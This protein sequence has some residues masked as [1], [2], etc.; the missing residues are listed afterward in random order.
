MR[1]AVAIMALLFALAIVSVANA[2][3]RLFEARLMP[4]THLVLQQ[5]IS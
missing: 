5:G 3:Q 2:G 4:R 1:T